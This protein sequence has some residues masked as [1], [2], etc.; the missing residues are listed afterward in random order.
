MRIYYCLTLLLFTAV[1]NAAPLKTV[2]QL[3]HNSSLKCQDGI[4]EKYANGFRFTVPGEKQQCT[5]DV[6][7]TLGNFQIYDQ[8]KLEIAT[9]NEKTGATFELFLATP[10]NTL[11]MKK[12]LR[13]KRGRHTY[14][15]RIEGLGLDRP[16]GFARLTIFN[17]ADNTHVP[18][19][20]CRKPVEW[21]S[22]RFSASGKGIETLP[23]FPD[24]TYLNMKKEKLAVVQK[25]YQQ[26]QK[27]FHELKKNQNWEQLYKLRNSIF[28]Q[29]EQ[30]ILGFLLEDHPAVYGS[31]G[32][33]D[34]IFRQKSF[35]GRL[36]TSVKIMAAR[37]ET[38]GAQIGIYSKRWLKN[39][40]VTCSI[41]SDQNGNRFPASA[42]SLTPIGFVRVPP[43]AYPAELELLIPDP[44]L[45]YLDKFNVEPG[46][47][48][49]VW[50]DVAVS[51]NQPAGLYKGEVIFTENGQELLR[52][53]LEVTVWNFT[54]PDKLTARRVFT[55][56]FRF[57]RRK[58][59]FE[60]IYAA[61]QADADAAR[62]YMF[63]ENPD[64]KQLSPSTL[65][66]IEQ[67]NEATSI[68]RAHHIPSDSFYR[69]ARY[70]IPGWQRR[71]NQ[72]IGSMFSMGYCNV[73][74]KE[75]LKI[76][77]PQVEAMKK[78]GTLD[79]AYLYG[80]DEIRHQKE[81]D[82][83]KFSFGAV[84][85][86]YPQLK[87]MA[88]ALDY[89]CGRRTGTADVVD[90][91]VMPTPN[92]MHVRNSE[93]VRTARERGVQVWWYPCNWPYPPTANFLLENTAVASRALCGFMMWKFKAD[94]ILYYSTTAWMANGFSESLLMG[95]QPVK[96][97]GIELLKKTNDPSKSIWRF[98]STGSK[99]EL[100]AIGI[101]KLSQKMP[102]HLSMETRVKRFSR[103][104]K[105]YFRATVTVNP[106]AWGKGREQFTLPLDMEN[107]TWQKQILDFE[108]ET[109]VRKFDL[110][111]QLNSPDA[112]IEV[113]NIELT[114]PGIFR[115]FRFPIRTV[116]RNGPVVNMEHF[117]NMIRSSGDG[118]LLL[119]AENGVI[120]SI[121]LKYIRDGFEDY[122]YL[123]MLQR[124]HDNIKKRGKTFPG[125]ETWMKTASEALKVSNELCQSL[126]RYAV[127]GETLLKHRKKIAE[128]LTQLPEEFLTDIREP[129]PKSPP[130]TP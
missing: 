96:T 38:E 29:L 122:E 45:T 59:H 20:D 7:L 120:P 24:Y 118:A 40:S 123:A 57:G 125:K 111:I 48:Q 126:D 113:R 42:V 66:L 65:K 92:Y 14:S 9:E 61:S 71:E 103:N 100:R 18:E 77:K 116:M 69:S 67:S 112:E 33:V 2:E 85:K 97:G 63:S 90:I 6:P 44:L 105:A 98:H 78:E 25:Q 128:L 115:R 88:T 11:L 13:L 79:L 32:G 86:A 130:R 34:K 119:P 102:I 93:E 64:E 1:S 3:H 4:V 54:L 81:F 117:P 121:R 76:L 10:P 91:W 41:L 84:K 104:K 58:N 68:L 108:P 80:Y 110:D 51:K 5:I 109:E 49:P 62:E 47:W 56:E 107:T 73:E 124:V 43:P 15:Y 8:V 82:K 26:L 70:P 87:T 99:V 55:N 127:H 30:Q 23:E 46:C 89:T 106:A 31:S 83:M 37:N 12:D 95:F 72:S 101:P 114:T 94:G 50:I 21:L 27:K 19:S 35:P 16:A 17:K 39:I 28:W 129:Q 52:V 53:P 60:S 75:L 36:L 22:L 74:T